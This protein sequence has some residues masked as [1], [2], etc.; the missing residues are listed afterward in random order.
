MEIAG[1]NT[2]H[3]TNR[4]HGIRISRFPFK[5]LCLSIALLGGAVTTA[6]ADS[7]K[8]VGTWKADVHF[9][10]CDSGQA[11]GEPFSALGTYYS[12]G[13]ATEV[14]SSGPSG[15]SPSYGTWAKAGKSNYAVYSQFWLYDVNGFYAGY[16]V[17]NRMLKVAKDGQTFDVRATTSRYDSNGVLL[18]SG[19]AAGTGERL[20]EPAPF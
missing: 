2:L 11:L 3:H 6:D 14:P 5:Q 17:L 12:D 8:L 1:M 15:R 18:G 19:C 9:V 7:A 16:Q 4:V 20:P 13:N 10:D